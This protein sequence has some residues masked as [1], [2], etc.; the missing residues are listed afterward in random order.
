M[1]SRAGKLSRKLQV[2][3][4]SVMCCHTLTILTEVSLFVIYSFQLYRIYKYE[5]QSVN[6]Y[7]C[8]KHTCLL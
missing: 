5:I 1:A 3:L 7:V 4:L 6:V 8:L 2:Y